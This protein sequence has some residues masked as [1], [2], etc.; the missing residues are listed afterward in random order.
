M[1]AC[2][3][4]GMRSIIRVRWSLLLMLCAGVDSAVAAQDSNATLR[5]R[6]DWGASFRRMQLDSGLAV[7]RVDPSQPLGRS[8]VRVGDR[9]VAINGYDLRSSGTPT[10]LRDIRGGDSVVAT[11]VRQGASSPLPMRFVAAPL[12]EERIEGV[13][14][15]YT[16]VRAPSGYRVRA[17]VT[18]P[19][20]A[21]RTRLPA[22]LFIPWL[23]CDPV[24]KPD[25]GTDGFA[26]T[27][28]DV[29]TG[30]GALLMRVEKPGNGDSEGPDCGEGRLDHELAAY[31]SAL[32]QL[33][34]RPDVD[35]TRIAV[36]GG[37]LGGALAPIIAAADRRGIVGV[38]S[39]GGFT[40]TWFEHMLEIERNRLTLSGVAPAEIN[41]ALAGFARFYAVYLFGATPEQA[42]GRDTLLRRLWY[43]EADSQ[44]GRHARFYHQVQALNVERTWE[45]LAREG[46]RGLFVWGDFDWIM[47]RADQERGV[48]ILNAGGRP[49]GSLVVLPNVDHGLMTYAT[50]HDGFN[51][52]NPEYRGQAA[53]AINTWLRE[54]F[55]V[56][57]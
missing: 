17:V 53:R 43:D 56:S 12:A 41:R 31:S 24:E 35:T 38:I 42:I 30:S 4:L 52:V 40:R 48:A 57:P 34:S 7:T 5:R 14:V 44:Y 39:L 21:S 47:G 20:A 22:I 36:M 25:P 6:V 46:V 37:S 55:R 15:E 3:V 49:L 45:E 32:R 19:S 28:R 8:G 27:L 29:A 54:I 51:D 23:S 10:Q 13:S 26:H 2:S 9:L 50:I 11:V 33:R 1:P 16:M 18:R